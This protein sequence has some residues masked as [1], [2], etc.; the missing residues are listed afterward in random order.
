M[1]FVV[2]TAST[3]FSVTRVIESL[4]RFAQNVVQFGVHASV[5][6]CW[7]V[8][9]NWRQSRM[10]YKVLGWVSLHMR[11]ITSCKHLRCRL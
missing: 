10:R 1:G 5:D 11:S 9:I 3:K 4:P 6:I 8:H 2:H 7:N